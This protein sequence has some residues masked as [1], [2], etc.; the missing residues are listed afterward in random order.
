MKEAEQAGKQLPICPICGIRE[1]YQAIKSGK[2]VMSFHYNS[3]FNP[4][5]CVDW[6]FSTI[7]WQIEAETCERTISIKH[8]NNI[9][10][11]FFKRQEGFA[12]LLGYKSEI[13]SVLFAK[14]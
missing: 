6:E 3:N 14:A 10:H 9:V 7:M 5:Q 11:Q 4:L 1:D 2:H 13:E 12:Q 8:S